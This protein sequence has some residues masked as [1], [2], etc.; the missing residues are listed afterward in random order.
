[1]DAGINP[2]TGDLSG[3]RISSLANAIYLRLTTP[4]GSWWAD[5]A[6]GS[7]LHE[8]QRSKDLPRVGRLA[9]QYAEDALAPL[10]ADRR[11]SAIN[12]GVEQHQDGWLRLQVEVTDRTGDVQVFRHLVR[13]S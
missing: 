11:A 2:T 9:R 1:M 13:V 10:I 6:L 5:P 8:L 12:V 7:R 4:L 3:E